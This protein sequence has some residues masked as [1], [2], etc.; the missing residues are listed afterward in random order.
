MFFNKNCEVIKLIQMIE[1]LFYFSCK[2]IFWDI[3]SNID[4]NMVD[5]DVAYSEKYIEIV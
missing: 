1:S 3:L 2:E 5:K 4:R